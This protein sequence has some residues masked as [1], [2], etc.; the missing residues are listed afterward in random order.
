MGEVGEG[1]EDGK[2]E[3]RPEGFLRGKEWEK[4]EDKVKNEEKKEEYKRQIK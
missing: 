1:G 3:R 2:E 4:W